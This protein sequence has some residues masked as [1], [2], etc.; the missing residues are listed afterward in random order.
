MFGDAAIVK[1]PLPPPVTVKVTVVVSTV[2]PAVPLTVI[3]YD[4]AA[5]D[6]PTFN[7]KVDVPVP[8]IDVGA[9]LTVT[10]AG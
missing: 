1:V 8:V 7:V 5:T 6:A 2:L 9:K 3:V 10:P 4:P